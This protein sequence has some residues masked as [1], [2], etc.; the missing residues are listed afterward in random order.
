MSTVVSTLLDKYL[1]SDR[2]DTRTAA[3]IWLLSIVKQVGSHPA[4]TSRLGKIQAAFGRLLAD[5]NE[6]VRV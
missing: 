4:V 5:N 6:V 3:C 2:S 1:F